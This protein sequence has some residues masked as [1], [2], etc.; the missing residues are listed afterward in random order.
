MGINLSALYAI[1]ALIAKEGITRR[2]S[3]RS[4]TPFSGIVLY[5]AAVIYGTVHNLVVYYII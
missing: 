2:G 5:L 3:L 1:L 4:E